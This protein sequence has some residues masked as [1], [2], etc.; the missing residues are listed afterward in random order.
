M[1][2]FTEEN[3][4]KTLY[5]LSFHNTEVSVHELSL[6]LDI[7]M[8]TVNSMVKKL[9]AKGLVAYEKYKPLSLTENGSKAA[10]LVIRKHRLT[11]IY[12]VEKMGFAWDQVHE[13]AEQVEHIK[14]PEFFDKIAEILNHPTVDP[15]GSPIP[16]KNGKL[17][18][19][20]YIKLSECSI[21]QKG[22]LASV[23]NSSD[24]FLKLLGSL[25]LKLGDSLE[26][27]EVQDFD[28]SMKVTVNQ[29]T[30]LNLSS[31]VCENL[32]IVKS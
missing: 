20:N 5:H 1:L 16:D 15:H 21:A 9:A 11:E 22:V 19:L 14:S 12:L 24:S 2:S 30:T 27:V 10:G 13:I 23:G 18:E 25:D 8:P 29:K 32:L 3:Y 4:L 28:K 6:S 31:L 17:P 7:K 26:I